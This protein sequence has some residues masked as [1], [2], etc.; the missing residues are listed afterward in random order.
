MKALRLAALVLYVA[1]LVQVGLLM[2][3]LPWSDAWGALLVRLPTSIAVWLDSPAIRGVVTAFG[4]LH[5]AFLAVE[6]TSIGSE[7]SSQSI[8]D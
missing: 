6:V 2:V 5:L 8:S 7:G 4:L 1:Y 3:M